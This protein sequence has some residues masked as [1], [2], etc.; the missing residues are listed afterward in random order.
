MR[1]VTLMPGRKVK[2][3]HN[4]DLV[5]HDKTCVPILELN[6]GK[7]PEEH[8]CDWL[9]YIAKPTREWLK[10]SKFKGKATIWMIINPSLNF[11]NDVF[12]QSAFLIVQ[13]FRECFFSFLY[14]GV[15]GGL[16]NKITC[17]DQIILHKNID[18]WSPVLHVEQGRVFV[19]VDAEEWE[20]V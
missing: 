5:F 15:K 6:I 10:K 1:K 20:E 13:G 7:L 3:L 18:G 16:G 12:T 8:R 14:G 9:S 11:E 19:R 17:L 4:P 2:T